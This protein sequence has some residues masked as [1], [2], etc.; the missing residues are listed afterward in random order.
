MTNFQKIEALRTIDQ[1]AQKANALW[2]QCENAKMQIADCRTVWHH[3]EDDDRQSNI[4]SRRVGR[5]T[6]GARQ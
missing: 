1:L 6:T 4:C 3:R 5:I 2:L